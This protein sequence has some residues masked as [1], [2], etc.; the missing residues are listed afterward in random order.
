MLTGGFWGVREG[1]RLH[2]Y[3]LLCRVPSEAFGCC[4]CEDCCM[5]WCSTLYTC[6]HTGT[7]LLR[8]FP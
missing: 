8:Y 7:C 1:T 2:F 4:R 3:F 6:G 5:E